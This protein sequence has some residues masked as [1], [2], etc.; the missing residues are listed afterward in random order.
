MSRVSRECA[1]QRV[2][3]V[4]EKVIELLGRLI[5]AHPHVIWVADASCGLAGTSIHYG[6]YFRSHMCPAS[7]RPVAHDGELSAYLL[8]PFFIHRCELLYLC[9]FFCP[10]LVQGTVKIRGLNTPISSWLPPRFAPNQYR[11]VWSIPICSCL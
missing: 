5:G 10:D 6:H 3:A 8:I 2:F 7:I 1:R 11:L 4:D 9:A